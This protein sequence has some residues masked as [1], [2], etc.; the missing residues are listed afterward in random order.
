[1]NLKTKNKIIS[2]TL[3]CTM[4]AYTLPVFAYTKDETV[5]SKVDSKGEKYQ[6]IVSTHIENK[7]ELEL[8]NDMSN[9]VNIENTNE[10]GR[11]H[12]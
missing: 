1:M 5:Y 3:L 9:L 10:I 8:I 12:V 6:T 7:E 4:C 11:A 2:G